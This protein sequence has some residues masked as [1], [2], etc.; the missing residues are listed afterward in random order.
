MR[1]LISLGVAFLVVV[2]NV[3]IAGRVTPELSSDIATGI[4]F[5]TF[6]GATITTAVVLAYLRRPTATTRRILMS[7]GVGIVNLAL[8]YGVCLAPY[9]KIFVKDAAI[10]VGLSAFLISLVTFVLLSLPTRQSNGGNR[11]ANAASE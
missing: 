6:I 1:I 10:N 4:I 9:P 8:L 11:A 7:L 5:M 3:L 2:L